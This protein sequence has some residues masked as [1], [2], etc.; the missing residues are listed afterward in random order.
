MQQL[1]V[2]LAAWAG[3]SL[4]L[5]WSHHG[6]ERFCP[7]GG[8][9]TLWSIL[10]EQ[11]FTCAAGPYNLTL[12]AALLLCAL[13]TRK[14]FCSWICP[15]GTVMQWLGAVGNRIRPKARTPPALAVGM[16]EPPRRI[17]LGLRWLR[18]A[19]LALVLWATVG[20]GEL[21]FR[22]YDPYYVLFSMHGHE[23]QWWSYLILA[24]LLL[25]ALV[26]PMAWC[27]YLC[28][29]GGVLWPISRLGWLRLRRSPESCSGCS[30]CVEVCPHGIPVSRLSEV[31]SGECTLCLDCVAACG[32]NRALTLAPARLHWKTPGWVVAM[33]LVIATAGGLATAE[34]ISF[35]S[36]QRVYGVGEGEEKTITFI[37]DGVRCVDTAM[38]AAGQLEGVAGVLSLTAHASDRRLQISYDAKGTNP[39][40][41]RASLEGPVFDKRSNVF[42][43]N[44]FRVVRIE[45]HSTEK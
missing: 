34:Q 40:K 10:T 14:A 19:V 33:I 3:L 27:R 43:F 20:T 6:V 1:V 22:P 29:L 13:L 28:P 25:L 24:G 5:G 42:L 38:L 32:D 9:E 30:R 41:I 23:V 15:V 26:I 39:Q 35:A 8:I 37:V 4:A 17:D 16:I 18:L 12:M 44:V 7:F 2:L 31:R 21:A 45:Y 11:K 36:Y